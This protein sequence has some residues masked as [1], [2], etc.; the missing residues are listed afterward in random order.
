MFVT[1]TTR[2]ARE[3]SALQRSLSDL[4]HTPLQE[5]AFYSH[6]S[7]FPVRVWG[8]IRCYYTQANLHRW[9]ERDGHTG[10]HLTEGHKDNEGTGAPLR[11]GGPGRA[12]HGLL[13]PGKERFRGD[14]S[15]IHKYLREEC[16]EDTARLLSEVPSARTRGHW[17]KL[18]HRRLS[19]NSRSTSVLC[20][21]WSTA[22]A[23]QRTWGL[24]LFS[25]TTMTLLAWS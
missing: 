16:T 14:L 18:A 19:L 10:S 5:S 11:W 7:Y 9:Q 20:G 21:W 4:Y 1:T 13:S 23:A 15:N 12:A 24:L 3:M 6:V 25:T 8:R 22:P 17:Q 2:R